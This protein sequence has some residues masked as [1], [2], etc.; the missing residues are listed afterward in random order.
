MIFDLIAVLLVGILLIFAGYAALQF[1]GK[2]PTRN[3]E[4][5]APFLRPAESQE[6]ESLLDPAQEANFALRMSRSEFRQWQRR[7]IHLMREYLLRMSH[8]ALVLI[9]W[10]NIEWTQEDCF[11]ERCREKQLLAQEMVQAATEFRMYSLLALV[12]TKLWLILPSELWF[13]IPSPS[14][15]RLRSAFGIDAVRSYHRLKD[16][17]GCLSLSYGN[18]YHHQLVG[19]L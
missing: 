7:R 14:L 10:G 5:V 9:E 6:L 18:E 19:R 3:M 1:L 2:F 8:N 15:P 11:S 4:D 12:K 17:A 16:A 13:L